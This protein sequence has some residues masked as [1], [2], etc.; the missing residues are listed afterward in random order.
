VEVL[1]LKVVGLKPGA[2]R[3]NNLIPVTLIKRAIGLHGGTFPFSIFSSACAT[4]TFVLRR[5]LRSQLRV[6]RVLRSVPS[7]TNTCLAARK[8]GTR[9]TRISISVG[10]ICRSIDCS[11]VQF[12]AIVV[13]RRTSRDMCLRARDPGRQLSAV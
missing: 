12:H 8:A 1:E 7:S 13:R 2:D 4:Q 11:A 9:Y 5:L 10:L 6:S 3:E